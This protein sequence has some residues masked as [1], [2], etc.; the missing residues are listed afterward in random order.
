MEKLIT[1]TTGLL[2]SLYLEKPL[3]FFLDWAACYNELFLRLHPDGFFCSCGSDKRYAHGYTNAKFPVYQCR[4]CSRTYSILSGT[5]LSGTK[6]GAKEIVLFMRLWA[7]GETPV[8][9]G[10]QVGLHRTSV[11]LL[12]DRLRL[13]AEHGGS[14]N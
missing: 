3:L 9:I 5:P 11:L 13:Y 10:Q 8:K 6:L 12:Q 4:E 7:D 1:H 2:P 14:A